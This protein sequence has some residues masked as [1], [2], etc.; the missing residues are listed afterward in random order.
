MRSL[1]RWPFLRSGGRVQNWA[2]GDLPSIAHHLAKTGPVRRDLN[3]DPDRSS[4]SAIA[5]NS[6]RPNGTR[7]SGRWLSQSVVLKH[8]LAHQAPA[9]AGARHVADARTERSFLASIR[10]AFASN[11]TQAIG[12]VA[13]DAQLDSFDPRPRPNSRVHAFSLGIG[14]APRFGLRRWRASARRASFSA[15]A[16]SLDPQQEIPA[17]QCSYTLFMETLH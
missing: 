12:Q 15:G 11:T 7:L 9:L 2:G 1:R 14:S 6:D 5:V 4:L 17:A 13:G 3:S 8:S 10:G 16:A